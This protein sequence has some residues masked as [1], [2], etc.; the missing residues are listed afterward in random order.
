MA[1]VQV[2]EP[3]LEVDFTDRGWRAAFA[4]RTGVVCDTN[5]SAFGLT[6]P[7]EGS[8]VEIGSP[9]IPSR[10]VVDGFGLEIPAA[11]TQ[12]LSVPASVGGANGRTDLIVGRLTAGPMDLKLHRIPGTEGSLALP[13]ASHN[14]TGTR[15]LLLYA[16]RR[17]QGQGLN[18]AIVTPLMPRIGHHYLVPATGT[19][20]ANASLGDI[21]TRGGTRYRYDFVGSS[22]DWVVESVPIRRLTGSSFTFGAAEPGWSQE[23]TQRLVVGADGVSLWVHIEVTK[24]GGEIIVS[25]SGS[26]GDNTNLLTLDAAWKPQVPVS[27]S[28]YVTSDAAIERNA[29]ARINAAGMVQVTSAQPGASVRKVTADFYYSLATA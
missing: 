3:E 6:K 17:I 4:G 28:A 12:S 2:F 25:S 16:I 8:T 29:G 22:V 1:E 5:G 27:G 18:Q 26:L 19:L 24:S 23:A 11:T 9:T 7:A 10:L 21:A 13:A 14:A 20:P 15:D